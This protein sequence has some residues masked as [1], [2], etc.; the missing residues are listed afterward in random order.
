MTSDWL[1]TLNDQTYPI[2]TKYLRLRFKFWS[3][4]LYNQSF[5]RRKVGENQQCTEWPQNDM[6]YLTVKRTLYMLLYIYSCIKVLIPRLNIRSVSL[7]DQPFTRYDVVEMGKIE[8]HR[9][10]SDWPWTLNGQ[11]Y[12][13]YTEYLP[14]SP[15]FWSVSLYWQ[16]FSRNSTFYNS[17]F[18]AMLN[19]PKKN[20]KKIAKRFQFRKSFNSFGRDPL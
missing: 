12:P 19:S 13:V 18:T 17:P 4:S 3:V 5:S 9:L 20:Q 8:M 7:Y 16:P 6:K 14:P 1:W 2:Y 15:K 10:T 11:K